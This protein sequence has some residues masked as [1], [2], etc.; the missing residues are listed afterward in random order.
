M[1]A[2]V[3][4]RAMSDLTPQ[5]RWKATWDALKAHRDDFPPGIDTIVEAR[6]I[7]ERQWRSS[8]SGLAPS[9]PLFLRRAV[10]I[11]CDLRLLSECCGVVLPPSL[12]GEM[13]LRTVR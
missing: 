2:E 8:C 12:V 5:R 10:A 1:V 13:M 3:Y 4:Q 9:S 6:I 7:S 11:E